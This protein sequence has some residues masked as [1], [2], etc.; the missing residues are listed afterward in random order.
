MNVLTVST[1]YVIF[2]VL[3][4]NL[5]FFLTKEL[6]DSARFLIWLLTLVAVLGVGYYL[7]QRFIGPPH[8]AWQESTVYVVFVFM[9]VLFSTPGYL[10]MKSRP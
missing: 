2:W 7:D 9:S 6:R 4:C 10:L 5:P 3:A 1:F 8:Q